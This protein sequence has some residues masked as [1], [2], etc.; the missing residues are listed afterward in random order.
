MRWTAEPPRQLKFKSEILLLLNLVAVVLRIA[1]RPLVKRLS[2]RETLTVL[3]L[4][5]YKYV[6][7]HF[8]LLPN[9]AFIVTSFIS[10][11]FFTE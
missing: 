6:V 1:L 4:S 3:T 10:L 9:F 5:L 11:N 8:S 7:R 2:E